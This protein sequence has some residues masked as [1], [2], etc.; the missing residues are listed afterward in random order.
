VQQQQQYGAMVVAV[1]VA[2]AQMM[3]HVSIYILTSA[4]ATRQ[5]LACCNSI[6]RC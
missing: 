4:P 3:L 1:A 6:Q 2:F 5:R